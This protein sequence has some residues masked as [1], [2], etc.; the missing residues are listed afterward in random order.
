[1]SYVTKNLKKL[2]QKDTYVHFL[3]TLRYSLYV[4]LHP[5]DGNWD[6]IHAKR[7]SYSA[8]NFIVILTLL[9]HIWKL[10]YT[11]FI[12]NEVNWEKVNIFKEIATILL[13]L[14]IFC[15]CN[16]A[17]TTLFDGKGHLGDIYKGTAYALT[18]YPLIQIPLIIISQFLTV[19]EG[20][21][22]E[23]FNTVS[24][25]WC[26]LLIFMAMMM[27]HQFGFGKTLLFTFIT[28][29]GMLVF[30]FIMLLFFSMI[31]QGVAYFVSLT[32]EVMFRL[33]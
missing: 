5:A 2:I 9:T 21:F 4:I 1:M 17:V 23:V 6:L 25:V 8:A 33:N 10:Q 16:W 32:R 28:I 3:Q 29:F 22:Y 20:T 15:I 13:P 27:I 26:A 14:A 19:E 12:F 7:G 24:L 11:S 18:P 31:S 30:I